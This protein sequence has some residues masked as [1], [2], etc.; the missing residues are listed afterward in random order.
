MIS[1]DDLWAK[2]SNTPE[3]II[4]DIELFFFSSEAW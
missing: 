4:D 3:A 2:Y 1:K